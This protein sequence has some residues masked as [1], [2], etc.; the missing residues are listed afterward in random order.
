[1]VSLSLM[2]FYAA[3]ESHEEHIARRASRGEPAGTRLQWGPAPLLRLQ[4]DGEALTYADTDGREA[5]TA[6]TAMEFV[7]K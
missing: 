3:R 2:T 5:P 6:T 7:S 1:M 4:D